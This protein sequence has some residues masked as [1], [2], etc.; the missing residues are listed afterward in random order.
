MEETIAAASGGE[1][2]K[3]SVRSINILKIQRFKN[4]NQMHMGYFECLLF[5]Q[6]FRILSKDN[7]TELLE[8]LLYPLGLCVWYFVGYR[9]YFFQKEAG[10]AVAVT[11]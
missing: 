8:K 6:K 1:I 9:L 2:P 7:P 4:W 10:D 5:G 11:K 3:M